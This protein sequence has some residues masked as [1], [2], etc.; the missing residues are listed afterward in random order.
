MPVLFD[1]KFARPLSL[2]TGQSRSCRRSGHTAVVWFPGRTIAICVF[3]RVEPK[4]THSSSS[5]SWKEQGQHWGSALVPFA[6]PLQSA[7]TAKAIS[8][9]HSPQRPSPSGPAQCDRSAAWMAV[10]PGDGRSNLAIHWPIPAEPVRH[11]WPRNG[12]HNGSS[13][14]GTVAASDARRGIKLCGHVRH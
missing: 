2:R 4:P 6:S 7:R 13:S 10:H 12:R 14:R 1:S 8:R 11:Q 9:D 5:R 3:V